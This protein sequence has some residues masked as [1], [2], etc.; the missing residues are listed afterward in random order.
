MKNELILSQDINVITAEINAYQRVAGEAIFEIGRRLKHVKEHDL[1]HGEFGKWLRNVDLTERTAQRFMQAHEQF[2]NATTSSG[3]PAGKLFEML[4]LPTEIDRH[5]FILQPH[6]VPSTGETKT[7]DE[8]TVRELR[9]VKNALKDKEEKNKQLIKLCENLKGELEE[10]KNKPVIIETKV[11]EK[12]IDNTDYESI[13][14]AKEELKRKER[15][16]ILLKNE[17]SALEEKMA[18]IEEENEEYQKLRTQIQYLTKEK[19]DLGRQIEAATSISSLVVEV[20]QL[21]HEKLAPVKYSRALQEMQ[22]D[23]IV[24]KNLSEIIYS[25]QTWCDDMKEY[26]PNKRKIIDMEVL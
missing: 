23:E 9:E 26:L 15:S 18:L 21:I 25:V 2:G 5:E 14:R 8:M 4:S 16:Y 22:N 24:M 1:A 6:T 10:E 17:K 20:E 12:E 3:L 19:E 13:E 11:V 7:V